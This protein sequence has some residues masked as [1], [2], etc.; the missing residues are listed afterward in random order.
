MPCH[1][2]QAG[3]DQGGEVGQPVG[4]SP[5]VVVPAE[6]LDLVAEG[7]SSSR[8]VEVQEYGVPTMSEDTIGS[9]V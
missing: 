7:P 8:R 6:D 3:T 1:A 2:G 5:L 4:V 9:A